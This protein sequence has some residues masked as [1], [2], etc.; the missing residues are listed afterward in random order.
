MKTQVDNNIIDLLDDET[1]KELNVRK[2]VYGE[3][4]VTDLRPS[5]G[6]SAQRSG[7]LH[8]SIVLQI[9]KKHNIHNKYI[10]QKRPPSRCHYGL[11]RK[12]DFALIT[13]KRTINIECKQLGDCESHF[14]KIS[15]CLMNLIQGCYGKHYWIV[16]DFNREKYNNKKIKKLIERCKV[17]KEQVALQG[18]TFELIL[19]DDIPN[20]LKILNNE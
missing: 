13:E 4:I 19:T 12:N 18:I 11:P 1:K 3:E 5:A 16:Y 8:E 7:A 2:D 10:I 17:V 6:E 14:D 9:L 20:H 15:H